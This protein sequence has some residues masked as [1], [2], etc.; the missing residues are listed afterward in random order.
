MFSS[1]CL[2]FFWSN[3]NEFYQCSFAKC[4]LTTLFQLRTF[5]NISFSHKKATNFLNVNNNECMTTKQTNS[6]EKSLAS[7]ETKIT[8]KRNHTNE[9]NMCIN[10]NHRCGQLCVECSFGLAKKFL[11]LTWNNILAFYSGWRKW[12]AEITIDRCNIRG[13]RWQSIE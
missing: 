5:N 3:F 8:Q 4:F 2:F 10:R 12:S 6:M 13:F 11:I 7:K 9:K 1:N